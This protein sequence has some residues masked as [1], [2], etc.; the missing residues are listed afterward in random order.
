MRNDDHGMTELFSGRSLMKY[1]RDSDDM[2]GIFSPESQPRCNMS[3][4]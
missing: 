1:I 4:M 3:E 2:F